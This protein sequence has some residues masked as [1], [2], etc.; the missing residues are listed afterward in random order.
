MMPA[1]SPASSHFARFVRE[2]ERSLV[3][4]CL[5]SLLLFGA[6]GAAGVI[7]DRIRVPVLYRVEKILNY[8]DDRWSRRLEYGEGLVNAKNYPEAVEYL[9]A[10]DREFPAQNVKHKRDQERERLLRALAQCYSEM[11]KKR[12]ALDTYRRLAEFDPR[13]FE[14][15]YL[16]AEAGLKFKETRIAEEQLAEVLRIHP[17]HM[18]SVRA[19]LKMHFDKGD[20][21]AVV[22]AYETYLNAF[23]IQPVTVAVG[24][25]STKVNVPVDGELHDFEVRLSHSPTTS[26]EIIFHVGEF[27]T[28]IKQVTLQ[29]PLLVGAPGVATKPVWPAKTSWRVQEM[30]PIRLGSYRALG[31]GAALHLDVPPQPRG[32]AAVHIRMRLFKPTDPDLWSMVET[33]YRRLLRLDGLKATLARSAVGMANGLDS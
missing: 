33:S 21:A 9:E 14:N 1:R 31:P 23:L 26:A 22:D 12:L 4:I 13:N 16:L 30:A 29:P 19:I 7:L 18:P 6:L 5:V 27:A 8:W 32:V 2:H 15:H 25:S 20:F 17:T 10:L 28:E 3:A 24:E 11:G